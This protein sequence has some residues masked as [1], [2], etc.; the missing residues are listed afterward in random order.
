MSSLIILLLRQ[1]L[2]M[3]LLILV[4]YL[5][6]RFKKITLEGS[7]SIGNILIYL[8]LPTIIIN[9][10]MVDRTTERL[11]G[12]GL[13]ALAAA[14]VLLLSVLISRLVLGKNVVENFSASFS[15]PGFFGTP[16]IL[17]S[18]SSGAVFYVASFIALLNMGQWTYG[19]WLLE[20]ADKE[21][22]LLS[23]EER[24][25]K[26][27]KTGSNVKGLL[28]RILKAP[29][30]IAIFIGL[31][32]FLSGIQVPDIP[33]RTLDFIA[34]LCTPL[35]MF[36]IGVYLAQV[37]LGKMM[38]KPRLY[39]VSLVRLILVPLATLLVL[40]LLP[41]AQ[42]EMKT[43]LLIAA[44]CPVGSNVAVYAQLYD[45]DYPYAVETVIISSLLSVITIPL[46]VYIAGYLWAL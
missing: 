15:N 2:I 45:G 8:A 6:V 34:G 1:I 31:I 12:L 21:G 42:L 37:D 20:N 25:K 43:A 30:M 3:F 7:K 18:L 5:M 41:K 16:L 10:F 38:I 14:L 44:S 35:A 11:I 29:F 17:A 32:I 22:R 46:M 23:K 36:T 28:L 27:G 19:V 26:A 40:W 39:L 24:N 4:G 33:K 13:S 9:G